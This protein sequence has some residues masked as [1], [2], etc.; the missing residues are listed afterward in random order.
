MSDNLLLTSLWLVPLI[1]MVAVLVVPRG[2]EDAI[3][4]VA[5]GVTAVTFVLTIL[6]LGVY[7][8]DGTAQR[9]LAERVVHNILTPGGGNLLSVPDE[10]QGL[11]DLVVRRAWIPYFNIQYYLGL[12]GISLSLVVLTGLISLLACLASWNITKQVKGYYALYL[13]LVA[14]MM[15]VFLSLDLFLFYVFFEVMLLPMYF[16]IAIWGGDNREYAAIKFLLYTLFGSVFILVSVLI[17]YFWQ[18]DI[19]A[20]STVNVTG[21]PVEFHGHSF[22]IVE[23]T[24]IASATSYY[25]RGIQAWIFILFL[26]GFM[27]KLPSFPFHTWLPDAHVQAPTPISMI[28]AGIL[29]KI[30]GYGMIRLAWPL[31]PAGAYD[32]SYFVAALGVFSILYGALVAMAQT[33][34]KKLV[35]YSSVSHMGYVTLGLAVMNIQN[36]PQYYAYGVIGAMFMMLA[37]GI[38]SAGMFFLVGVIYDRAHT[39]D[40]DKLGGLNNIM[41]LYGAI[42]YVIFFGSM[43][44]PGLCGFVAEVFVVLSSFNYSIPL[45][46]LAAAAVI[47]TAGYILWTVQRVFLG[48]S[49]T[50]KGLPDMNL[51]ELTI[52]V[53]LVVLTVAM[54]V[55]PN[56]LVLSWVNPSVNQ[57]V[58][59]VVHARELNAQVPRAAVVAPATPAIAS[60]GR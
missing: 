21:N 39:R 58:N 20:I 23:L 32:W 43:G 31:A 7:L 55:F 36:D 56:A 37:H 54:G 19:T 59:S 42:S 17:L 5:L 34:F 14:S 12:D 38:T 4:Y 52:A 57:M 45:A 27:V 50:W 29:L 16:L 44:L 60:R 11:G 48:R 35:A 9:P 6:V 22:D 33:D 25:G 49:E 1:G 8:A 53:P 30:G 2:R 51:R 3:K 24:T 15:G 28:L 41:P 13:L 10:S 47:L 26:V 18:T 40:L 46:V